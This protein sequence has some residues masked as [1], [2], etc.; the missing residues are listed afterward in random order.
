MKVGSNMSNTTA[1]DIISKL[2]P[3]DPTATVYENLHSR[4]HQQQQVMP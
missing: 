1:F 2:K 3:C 4:G